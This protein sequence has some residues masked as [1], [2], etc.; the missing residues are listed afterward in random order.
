M[1]NQKIKPNFKLQIIVFN[2]Y[3]KKVFFYFFSYASLHTFK[4]LLFKYLN[5]A[6]M[7]E[8]EVF[9]FSVQ[10]NLQNVIFIDMLLQTL[11]TFYIL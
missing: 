10:F 5:Y 8:K 7:T 1:K 4:H 3:L 11:V 9:K 6:M 2:L